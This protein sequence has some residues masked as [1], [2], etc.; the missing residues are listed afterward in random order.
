VH[1]YKFYLLAMLVCFDVGVLIAS[2]GLLTSRFVTPPI[3]I[4]LV[5]AI[6][7]V[8]GSFTKVYS[9]LGKNMWDCSCSQLEKIE[10]V[11][12]YDLVMRFLL[13]SVVCAC[14]YCLVPELQKFV[15][16]EVAISLSV[17][18]GF[19]GAGVVF[20]LAYRVDLVAKIVKRLP[21]ARK[22]ESDEDKDND[23]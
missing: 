13:I 23:N 14:A 5:L 12:V 18:S 20:F 21:S 6:L 15:E 7:T 11:R 16:R 10:A 8:V 22:K 2:S 19:K 3:F 9:E 17:A 4:G 1:S